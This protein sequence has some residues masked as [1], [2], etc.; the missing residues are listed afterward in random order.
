M[1][2]SLIVTQNLVRTYKLPEVEIPVLKGINIELG[3]GEMVSIMGPS[4]CGKSTLMHLL[5]LLDSPTSGSILFEGE[6]MSRLSEF[7]RADFRS[8]KVGFVFQSFNL[9]KK[10]SSLENVMLPL[11]YSHKSGGS[12]KRARTLLSEVGLSART[13]HVTSKLSGGEQQ[14]VAIARSLI[15]DPPLILADEPTGNLDSKAGV[16]IMN[17]L[18]GLNAKGKTIVIVTHDVSIAESCQR[19]I[20]M[21][22]VE[23]V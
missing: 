15:N 23:I 14:R 8:D 1:N 18:K 6:D 21:R 22:D 11:I 4:G 17:L 10:F 16:E 9:L 5:G 2:S 19:M 13:N 20:R 7:Q 12:E 3:R